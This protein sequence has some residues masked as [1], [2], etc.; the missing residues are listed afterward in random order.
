MKISLLVWVLLCG[1]FNF[2]FCAYANDE[3]ADESAIFEKRLYNALTQKNNP[4]LMQLLQFSKEY[5]NSQ[6]ADDT[7]V[8]TTYIAFTGALSGDDKERMLNY[9]ND[10][11]H[12]AADH[13]NGILE[14]VTY[15]K[16]IAIVAPDIG[17]ELFG[18]DALRI[19]YGYMGFYMRGMVAAKYK[20]WPSVITNYSVLTNKLGFSKN[21]AG[22]FA[23]DIYPALASAY[24]KTGRLQDAEKIANESLTN[25]PNDKW[26]SE[27]MGKVLRSIKK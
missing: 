20:D 19:P 7:W 8:V 23:Y 2:A 17:N 5:P 11:E 9:A 26:L 18:P 12:F 1:L 21:Y 25:I 24:F 22:S 13:P 16:F 4:T 10:I 3:K 15:R 6:F 14:E 27:F